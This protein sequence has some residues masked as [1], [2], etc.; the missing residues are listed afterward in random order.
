MNVGEGTIAIVIRAKDEASRV[1]NGVSGNTGKMDKAMRGAKVAATAALGSIVA[2][3]TKSVKTWESYGGAVSKLTKLSDV[4]T[5]S[6]SRLVGQWQRYGVSAEGG[7]K[8][9]IMLSKQIDAAKQG[10]ATAIESF[11]RVGVSVADLNTLGATDIMAKARDG[12]SAMGPSAERTAL[13]LKLMGKGG[14]EML[15]WVNA[16]AGDLGTLNGKLEDLGMVWG[17]KQLKDYKDLA[18]AQKEMSLEWTAFQLKLAQSVVPALMDLA[19]VFMAVFEAMQPLAP[20]L[21][22]VAAGLAAFLVVGKIYSMMAPLIG[23]LKSFAIFAK[24]A[25]AAQW[26]WNAALSANPIGIIILAIVALV[27]AFVIL[28]KKCDWFRNFWLALWEYVKAAFA[29][30]WPAIKAVAGAIIRGLK[31]AWNAIHRAVVAFWKWAGPYIKKAVKVWWLQIKLTMAAIL[32]VAKTAWKL[33]TAVIRGAIANIK[34]IVHTIQTLVAFV[35]GVFNAI[36]NVAVTVGRS[37]ASAVSTIWHGIKNTAQTVWNGIVGVVRSSWS[38]IAGFVN[39][40]I[41]AF[42]WVMSKV[43]G[44][45]GKQIPKLPT[46][47]DSRTAAQIAAAATGSARGVRQA[48]GDDSRRQPGTGDFGSTIKSALSSLNPFDLLKKIPWP[49]APGGMFGGAGAELLNL[50]KEAVENLV[51]RALGSLFGGGGSADVSG[52][53]YSWAYALAKRFGLVVTSTFRPG[54]I[55]AAGNISD[56]GTY[57]RAADIAGSTGGMGTLWN[58]VKSTAGSWKQ[59]IYQHQM[60]NYGR[61]Q[62]YGPSDHFDHVHLARATGDDSRSARERAGGGGMIV[63]QAAPVELVVPVYVDSELVAEHVITIQDGQARQ[64]ARTFGTGSA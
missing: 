18:Q 37:I 58:Y 43:P 47:D 22:Y 57:G 29:A 19:G 51:K 46:G 41:G 13:M 25:T 8:G 60:L 16:S 45:S 5:E 40:V 64:Y 63:Q 39:K 44:L 34:A 21:K 55:T 31:A 56:H 59:A 36:R 14:V 23:A 30:V 42:N 35:R 2:V 24:I 48:V 11:K 7:A 1:I 10:N 54:A 28:W 26:L 38:T 49:G 52:A 61:L 3:G 17:D 50:V 53:G 12:L 27:A 33:I 9:V 62:Y 6:A 32:L 15:T 20:V 4:S